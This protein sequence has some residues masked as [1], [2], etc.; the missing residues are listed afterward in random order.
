MD[1][2]WNI[3]QGGSSFVGSPR[4]LKGTHRISV[5][6]LRRSIL[7]SNSQDFCTMIQ[8]RTSHD[9]RRKDP[10]KE[11]TKFLCKGP[12]KQLAGSLCEEP[13]ARSRKKGP[14]RI[15][16]TIVQ[17]LQGTVVWSLC[18]D[19]PKEFYASTEPPRPA[20][21]NYCWYLLVAPFMSRT[22]ANV[23]DFWATCTLKVQW[24]ERKQNVS[25]ILRL[26]H[27]AMFLHLRRWTLH[28]MIW[29]FKPR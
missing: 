21:K 7:W 14:E 29:S 12:V 20:M 11:R 17:E 4:C 16:I 9:L 24:P 23:L 6:Y 27:Q 26:P 18:K 15:H 25:G 22:T 28:S 5:R 8:V 3:L 13:C 2:L 1:W 19:L 10:C